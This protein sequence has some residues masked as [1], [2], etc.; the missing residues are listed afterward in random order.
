MQ[1]QPKS[2]P[3]NTSVNDLWPSSAKCTIIALGSYRTKKKNCYF[4][5]LIFFPFELFR[6][7]S[8]TPLFFQFVSSNVCKLPTTSRICLFNFVSNHVESLID[9][10]LLNQSTSSVQGLLFWFQ[11]WT[12]NYLNFRFVGFAVL[13]Q[14]KDR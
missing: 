5:N 6:R 3:N 1:E 12:K 14:F 2:C 11:K 8:K 13:P 7:L 4:Q 10:F 9:R